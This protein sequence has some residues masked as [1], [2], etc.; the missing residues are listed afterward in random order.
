MFANV[1]AL[2]LRVLLVAGLIAVTSVSV[3]QVAN[4]QASAAKEW[5]WMGGSST[6]QI[7]I[8]G[9]FFVCGGAYGTLGTPAVGNIPGSRD[10]AATW[11]DSSGH[12]W[13][14]GGESTIS[15]HDDAGHTVGVYAV[16]IDDVWEFNPYTNEWTWMGGSSGEYDETGAYGTLGVPAAG[17][18]PGGREGAA[19]WTDSSGNLWLFGGQ[20]FS[21]SVTQLP[22]Y[23]LP[24]VNNIS[25]NLNDLWK[26]NP[27][28]NEWTWMGGSSTLG[29]GCTYRPF[30]G[31]S[32]VYGTLGVPAAGN[33]PGGRYDA[34]SWADSSGHFWLFGGQVVNA[35]GNSGILNDLWE[36]DPS[37]NQWTW[38]GGSSTG[39]PGVYGTLGVPA[40]GNIPGG[41][42]GAASWTDSSGNFWL[43]AAR[44]KLLISSMAISTTYGSSILPRTNGPGWAEAARC[45]NLVASPA[46][47]ARW[48]C[49]LP[50]TSPEAAI[51]LRAGPTAAAI[52][53]S[54]GA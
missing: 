25:Y 49:L 27:S 10:G 54:L 39:Q 34:A 31:R 36:F 46:C 15:V 17:N 43:L 42:E 29:S 2:R 20:N 38:M 13:L 33:I 1:Q 7:C 26:F 3:R 21:L 45:S 22:G 12:L 44:A 50:G 9:P 32:G 6:V 14:Y 23:I 28:T 51:W 11:T 5:T 30:C 35:N 18:F 52:S 48:A 4:A 37:M 8:T 24:E 19:S 40:A 53:G 47:T 16:G 41:R